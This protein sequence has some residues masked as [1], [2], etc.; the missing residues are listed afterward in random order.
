[1]TEKRD[2]LRV[3]RLSSLSST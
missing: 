1:M 3:L 2:Y